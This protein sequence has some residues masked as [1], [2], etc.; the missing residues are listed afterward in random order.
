VLLLLLLLLA[1]WL[2]LLQS[3]RFGHACGVNEDVD[4]VSHV[5]M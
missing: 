1:L 5:T 2:Q 4:G 3:S